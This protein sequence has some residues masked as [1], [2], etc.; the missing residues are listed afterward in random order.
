M[1]VKKLT[2]TLSF[3]DYKK[4]FEVICKY[5][6]VE[7]GQY[8]IIEFLIRSLLKND[9]CIINVSTRRSTK[10]RQEEK[11]KSPTGFPDLVIINTKNKDVPVQCAIEVKFP[12]H[13]NIL[14]DDKYLE[15]VYGHIDKFKNVIYTDGIHWRFYKDGKNKSSK[16]INLGTIKNNDS[17][18]NVE[19]NENAS[20]DWDNLLDT[21]TNFLNNLKESAIK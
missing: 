8:W 4:E 3:E 2:Y 5:N 9:L 12:I 18:I 13:N 10:N 7:V 15:Q 14:D 21:I 17:K 6:P 1:A 20:N 16:T 11:Y 19:F